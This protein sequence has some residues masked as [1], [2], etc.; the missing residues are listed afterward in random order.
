MTFYPRSTPQVLWSSESQPYRHSFSPSSRQSGQIC[1][2]LKTDILLYHL[3]WMIW[4]CCVIL[5][6]IQNTYD[7]ETQSRAFNVLMFC[8]SPQKQRIQGNCHQLSVNLPLLQ[9]KIKVWRAKRVSKKVSL[10]KSTHEG[11]VFS[12]CFVSVSLLRCHGMLCPCLDVPW[13]LIQGEMMDTPTL[14]S[15]VNHY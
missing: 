5:G 13:A 4:G 9:S 11:K 12:I 10:Q 2:S 15:E 3:K 1:P 14:A 8:E 6:W 7:M